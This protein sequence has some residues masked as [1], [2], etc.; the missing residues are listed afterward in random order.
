MLAQFRSGL[1]AAIRELN[2]ADGTDADWIRAWDQYNESAPTL[3]FYG[4]L[5]AI[6]G[7]GKPLSLLDVGCGMQRTTSMLVDHGLNLDVYTAID[8]RSECGQSEAMSKISKARFVCKNYEEVDESDLEGGSYDLIIVDIEPH[9]RE[10]QVYERFKRFMK[11]VHLCILKHVGSMAL[12]GSAMADR[13]IDAYLKSGHVHDFYA[14]ED[15]QRG[16]RDVFLIMSSAP[17]LLDAQCQELALGNVTNWVD[18]GVPR[19][20][21]CK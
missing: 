7:G 1:R 18:S 20:V 15:L 19:H 4:G 17:V 10:E 2:D 21:K 3:A 8:K 14:Q 5:V 12:Y 11:P 9:G 6:E 13:F 16:F